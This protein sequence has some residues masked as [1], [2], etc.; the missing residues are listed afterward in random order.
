LGL[1]NWNKLITIQH[2]TNEHY[3]LHISPTT[4]LVARLS[5]GDKTGTKTAP[6]TSLDTLRAT[7]LLPSTTEHRKLPKETRPLLTTI[8]TFWIKFITPDN[9][10][11]HRPNFYANLMKASTAN[12]NSNK[13]PAT[14][15]PETLSTTD[16]SNPAPLHIMEIKDY[17]TLLHNTIYHVTQLK[18]DHLTTKHLCQHIDRGFTLEHLA[19]IH[20]EDED[21]PI[22]DIPFQ[23]TWKAVW[24]SEDTARSLPNGNLA[25]HNY[26][27]RKLP[28]K[29]KART[30]PPI[31]PHRQC[32]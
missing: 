31:P 25:I 22:L 21:S 6:R 30:A 13:R 8:H 12:V 17:K 2:H 1:T 29:K 23:A 11:S 9:L 7:L 16:V 5:N 4:A 20:P 15:I 24:I 14:R 26:K 28:H 18:T 10:P 19:R 32:G 3:T 27:I